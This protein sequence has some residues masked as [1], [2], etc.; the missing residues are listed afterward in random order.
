MSAGCW[1]ASAPCLL[2]RRSR[3][4]AR[5]CDGCEWRDPV[6]ATSM[7]CRLWLLVSVGQWRA[8]LCVCSS[9]A[10]AHQRLTLEVEPP[11]AVA[12]PWPAAGAASSHLLPSPLS[13]LHQQRGHP[14]GTPGQ[15]CWAPALPAGTNTWCPAMPR[16]AALAHLPGRAQLFPQWRGNAP[17]HAP[18]EAAPQKQW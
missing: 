9:E 17:S 13:S 10:S 4:R 12:Q 5:R 18:R 1:A 16:A 14:P 15:P 2:G 3:G 11:R 6:S 8:A 7:E